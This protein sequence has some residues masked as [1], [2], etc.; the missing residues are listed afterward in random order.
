[1]LLVCGFYHL[2]AFTANATRLP[3]EAFAARFPG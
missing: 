3:L 1:M 2:I